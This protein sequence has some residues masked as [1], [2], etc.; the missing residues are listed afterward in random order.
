MTKRYSTI[1]HIGGFLLIPMLLLGG[2]TSS[3]WAQ[4]ESTIDISKNEFTR[5]EWKA[6]AIRMFEEPEKFNPIPGQLLVYFQE[7]TTQEEALEVLNR[8][9]LSFL[10]SCPVD[11]GGG[12]GSSDEGAV[13]G[14]GSG[15]GDPGAQTGAPGGSGNGSSGF[16]CQAQDVW[17][18]DSYSG[19]VL[20][21]PGAEV[22]WITT[23]FDEEAAVHHILGVGGAINRSPQGTETRIAEAFDQGNFV[24]GRIIVSFLEETSLEQA[25]AIL[26]KYGLFIETDEICIPAET[27]EGGTAPAYCYND[28]WNANLSIAFVDVPVG[29][30][31]EIALHLIANENA[32]AYVEPDYIVTIAG[33]GANTNLP[34]PQPTPQEGNILSGFVEAVSQFF[35]GIL[36]FF[37]LR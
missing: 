16:P 7:G 2:I 32:I 11:Q 21:T 18:A 6:Q 20:V 29:Q 10:Q 35:G 28:K 15:S 14:G 19:I 12:S 30:E 34:T 27:T 4:D 25:Q 3:V 8:Y 24:Q 37:G 26:G 33:N 36:G 13:Q 22:E 1:A 23:L 9:D 5:E 17:Y 31:K